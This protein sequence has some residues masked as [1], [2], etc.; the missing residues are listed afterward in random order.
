MS[1]T[2]A[3]IVETFKISGGPTPYAPQ[4]G[5]PGVFRGIGVHFTREEIL[6][7]RAH[8]FKSVGESSPFSPQRSR[9]GLYF[10][11][12]YVFF[13]WLSGAYSNYFLIFTEGRLPQGPGGVKPG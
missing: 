2:S 12:F 4:F 1:F 8:L 7:A 6:L 13:C 11:H 10:A 5:Q 3:L 9:S